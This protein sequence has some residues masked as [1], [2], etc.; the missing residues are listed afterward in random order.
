MQPNR[1][2]GSNQPQVVGGIQDQK[3]DLVGGIIAGFVHATHGQSG[4]H[5]VAVLNLCG[6]LLAQ[7]GQLVELDE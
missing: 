1:N 7:E 4:S 6:P 3:T 2:V 5:G